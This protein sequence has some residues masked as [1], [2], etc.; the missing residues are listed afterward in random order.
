MNNDYQTPV[1]YATSSKGQ[2]KTWLGNAKNMGAYTIVTT[3]FGLKGNSL[4]TQE[5]EVRE[6]KNI[7][8]S[9]ETTHFEQAV[10]ELQSKEN[11]KRDKGYTDN[12]E[13][14]STPIL[15]MLALQFDK[16][17]HN[18][19]Y[20][21]FVQPKLDGVRMTCHLTENNEVEM[22]SRKGK[23]FTF[24]P[25]LEKE[26]HHALVD[27]GKRLRRMYMIENISSLYFDGELYSEE[28]TFQELAGAVR[29]GENEDDI[30]KKI[31]YVIFDYFDTENICLPFEERWESIWPIA[32]QVVLEPYNHIKIIHNGVKCMA[33]DEDEV[34]EITAN[35]IG[36]GYEGGIV[37]NKSGLYK[38]NHRSPDLQ[39]L[40]TFQDR[41]YPITG[42][43]EGTN[44][45]KGCVIWECETD[46]GER[47]H[48]RP[49]GTMGQRRQWFNNG[50]E[51]IGSD[52]TVRF[53]ELTTDGIPRFPVGVALRGY[54]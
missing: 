18:V 35:F 50:D 32:S 51:F 26:L 20:P 36:N 19:N 17:K 44:T 41:E 34:R 53:Q 10:K 22:F 5:K 43:K 23:P 40:K 27:L 15:P 3:R 28:L 16:R 2:I 39:K 13:A 54:E 47:F 33:L 21:C 52:L 4:Q 14:I 48:V 25:G 6:G 8:R 49:K 24:M 1:L 29:R 45:E 46:N 37:R 12:S 9:N 42:Y 11:R 30:I 31:H 7:G 38:L